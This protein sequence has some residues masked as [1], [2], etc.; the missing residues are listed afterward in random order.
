MAEQSVKCVLTHDL[1]KLK[2]NLEN[3]V[4]VFRII[5][6]F[7]IAL[8]KNKDDAITDELRKVHDRHD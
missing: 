2:T 7:E 5:L 8:G 1:E 4:I 6:A 3:S